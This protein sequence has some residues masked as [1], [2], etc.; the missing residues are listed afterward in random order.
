MYLTVAGA[1]Q[2]N[3]TLSANGYNCAAWGGG[4][5][6]GGSVM[7]SAGS[8]AGD[9]AVNANGGY[10]DYNNG[11]G[12]GGGGRIAIATGVNAFIGT[13][14]ATGGNGWSPNWGNGG[15]A[16]TIYTVLTGQTGMV[17]WTTAIKAD[18]RLLATNPAELDQFAGTLADLTVQNCAFAVPANGTPVRNLQVNANG[19]G[20]AARGGKS[21][22]ILDFSIQGNATVNALAAISMKTA[23][24]YAANEGGPGAGVTVWNQYGGG[25][26]YGGYGGTGYAGGVGGAGV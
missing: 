23:A 24:G 15:G 14:S 9:G 7:V 16:G 3:G 1:L 20:S 18:R 12:G 21:S 6:A 17:R 26:G 25:G 22:S 5:G 11:G 2:L 10:G 4:G 19:P 8:F 13:M